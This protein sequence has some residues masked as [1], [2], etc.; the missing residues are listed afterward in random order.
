MLELRYGDIKFGAQAVFQAAQ[1]LALVLERLRMLD[2]KLESKQADGH[3]RLRRRNYLLQNWRLPTA[4]GRSGIDVA[5]GGGFRGRNLGDLE[6]FQNIANLHVIE[7]G[8]AR[9]ALK[10]GANFADIVLKAFQGTE[11]GGVNHG[12]VTQHA[13]LAVTFEHAIHDIAAGDGAGALD[14]ESVANFGAAQVG[15]GTDR[16]EQA[17]HGFL[18]FVG[19]FVNDGVSANVDMLLLR[20]IR[21]FAIRANPEGNDNGSR[22]RGQQH[23]VFGDRADA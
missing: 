10:S 13:N 17:C 6:A 19:N 5:F 3:A 9:A 1:Y 8:D 16:F 4:R 20:E 22:R 23:I 14:A 15:F 7:I 18:N 12:S 21:G 2:M 11:L